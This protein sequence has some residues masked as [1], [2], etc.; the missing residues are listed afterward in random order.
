[1]PGAP[2]YQVLRSLNGGSLT[3]VARVQ[4]GTSDPVEY[5]D[6]LGGGSGTRAL[7]A[8]KALDAAGNATTATMSNEITLEAKA[9]SSTGDVTDATDEPARRVLGS[10][11]GHAHVASARKRDPVHGA[12]ADRREGAAHHP[13]CARDRC[14]AVRR[15][16]DGTRRHAA[17]IP[18]RMR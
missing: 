3:L 16:G 11:H 10:G 2:A 5:S 15:F 13:A 7:Y 12:P 9:T 8:V 17:A 18:A 6:Y 14:V 4:A 1:M